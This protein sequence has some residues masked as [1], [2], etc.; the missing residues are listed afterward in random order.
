MH[1]APH[2]TP[3]R[4]HAAFAL[5]LVIAIIVLASILVTAILTRH[6]GAAMLAQR[7]F[8]S[9]AE[10]HAFKGLEEGIT[11]WINNNSGTPLMDA[12]D[13]DGQAF[14]MELP[15]G[16]ALV[17]YFEDGQGLALGQFSGLADGDLEDAASVIDELRKGA[18]NRAPSFVRREGPLA[19]SLLSAPRDV[20]DAGFRA[21]VSGTTADSLTREVLSLRSGGEL[22]QESFGEAMNRASV[23][24]EDRYRLSR[25]F[26][27]EPTLYTVWVESWSAQGR[28]PDVTYKALCLAGGR[29]SAT[30]SATGVVRNSAFLSW[31]RVYDQPRA[32]NRP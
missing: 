24:T 16:N 8:T 7:H 5:P 4:A 9:Y 12:L 20:L 22:T 32:A 13:D 31:E 30:R 29:T 23:P 18:G 26:T 10:H 11:A 25:L 2:K 27:T 3:A 14:T 28:Q 15:G 21:V 1:A 6:S 19:I 17:V